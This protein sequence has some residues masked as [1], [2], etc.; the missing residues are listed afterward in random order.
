MNYLEDSRL[1]F[2]S[3]GVMTHILSHPEWTIEE[4][5]SSHS[6]GESSVRQAIKELIDLGY[7]EKNRITDQ[8]GRVKKWSY[9]LNE[10]D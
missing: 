6:D 8:K 4:L 7:L 9:T 1:S 5:I 3:V 2:K 10:A